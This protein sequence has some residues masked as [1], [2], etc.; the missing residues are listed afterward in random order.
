[1]I[2]TVDQ[3]GDWAC[4]ITSP[5]LAHLF[6]N[7]WATANYTLPCPVTATRSMIEHTTH[8]NLKSIFIDILVLMDNVITTTLIIITMNRA[9]N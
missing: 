4:A 9:Y 2:L 8:L 5:I 3:H 7:L 1:M 6:N